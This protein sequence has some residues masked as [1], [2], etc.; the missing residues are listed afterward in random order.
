MSSA[1][2]SPLAILAPD[3]YAKQ[4]SIQRR[5]ALA[6]SLMQSG[7]DPGKGAYGG[8]RSAGNEILGAI[9]SR[10]GD[11]DMAQLYSPQAAPNQS[12]PSPQLTTGPQET[13]SSP[14]PT[15]QPQSQGSMPGG[16][17]S[18]QAL[19][20]ALSGQPR[21]TNIPDALSGGIPDLPGMSH[22]Q[23]MLAYLQSPNAYFTALAASKAPTN[24]M[25]NAAFVD[26]NNP[27][28]QQQAVGGVLTKSGTITGRAGN[29]LIGPNGQTSYVPP[30]APAGYTYIQGQDGR[31]Y[32]VQIGG[33]P[34]AVAGSAYAQ[35]VPK[36]M[37]TPQT[38]FGPD[39]LP[40][41]SNALQAS[42]NGA[43]AAALGI[44]GQPPQQQ[45][46]GI[47]TNNPG[48]LQPGGQQANY[49]TPA[50]GILRASQNL[51]AY[52]AQG[53]NTLSGI[54]GKWAPGAQSQPYIADAA[55]RLGVDPNQPLDLKNPQ[56]KGAVLDAIFT[57]ENGAGTV[58][59]PQSLRPELPQGQATYMQGQAKDSADRHDATVAAASESPMRINVLD[60]IINLSKS[61]VATG[62]G[63]DWQNT[64]L[65]YAA[66]VPGL[67]KVMG[68]AKDNV[69]KFQ[70][71]QK[72]TYQNAIRSWQAAGGTGTDAQMESMAHANPNDHLF[73]EALQGIAQ[74]GKAAELAVQGKANAQDAFLSRAGQTPQ[75]QIAF[76]NQWR[77][78]F[79]PKVFQYQLMNPQ[80]KQAF[81]ASLRPA[82]AKALVDKTQRLKQLGAIQ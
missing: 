29:A 52:A 42:G 81:A 36:A 5:Q 4:L 17:S 63:Q 66:N 70:E 14:T 30:Q 45:P 68:P 64:V 12:A 73:P 25:K 51:D 59:A 26:P 19:G 15:V 48:N 40:V 37:L 65:G 54:I 8:L 1:G 49:G 47:R 13:A 39:N 10:S 35:G 71:L 44:G 21:P 27:Q 16:A 57:H 50:E 60:N 7:S 24:E 75:N 74:W 82:D 76:E 61:G 9:L 11:K 55:K 3:L 53:I 67:S 2:F 31:P 69:S 38:Q 62:P 20:Q 79:D 41:N 43:A 72:F 23:S 22:Q 32:L 46:M 80:E 18:P 78:S 77:N 34:Q 58:P 6:Q 33:G 28:A 56:V